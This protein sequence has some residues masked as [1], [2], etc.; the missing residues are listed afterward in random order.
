TLTAPTQ[1][2]G[3]TYTNGGTTQ[4]IGSLGVTLVECRRFCVGRSTRVQQRS[5]QATSP[6]ATRST[7]ITCARPNSITFN[8]CWNLVRDQG[9]GGSNPLSPTIIFKHLNVTS[10]F[11]STS[12]VSKL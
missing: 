1:V 7:A 4:S 5:T 6:T 3:V 9:V 12:M 11:P 10:G 8:N 2:T